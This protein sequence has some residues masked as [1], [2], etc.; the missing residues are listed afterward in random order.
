M[1]STFLWLVLPELCSS[2]LRDTAGARLTAL[3]PEAQWCT[4]QL[5]T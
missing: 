5:N 3:I 4:T 1:F 2:V